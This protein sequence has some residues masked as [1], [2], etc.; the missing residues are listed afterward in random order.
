M[1]AEYLL[2]SPYRFS[3]AFGR[4]RFQ[5]FWGA[6][7]GN[8]SILAERRRW[9]AEDQER[10]FAVLPGTEPLL[11]EARELGVKAQILPRRDG[12]TPSDPLSIARELGENW[13]PDFLVLKRES[14]VARLVAGCVCFPSS[15]SLE[16]KIGRPIEEIHGVV[17]G[18]NTALGPQI[19]TFLDRIKPGVSWTR[20]N[21]GLSRSPEWNQHPARRTPRLDERVTLDQVYFRVEEQSLVALPK[22]RGVLFG[23]RLKVTPLAGISGLPEAKMLAQLLETMPEEM[24]KYKGLY[25]AR[26]RIVALLKGP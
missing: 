25:Q 20:N 14:G 19:A 7:A 10:Y 23:I 4:G 1:I 12:R 13:E 18:L 2:E 22:S 15:W 8:Q 24:A 3:I 26:E 11:E 21:W 16:E 9:L 5:D 17:P 6:T